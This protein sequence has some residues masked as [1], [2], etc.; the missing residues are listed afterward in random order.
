MEKAWC[1]S[2]KIKWLISLNVLAF[3]DHTFSI[4]KDN[5]LQSVFVVNNYIVDSFNKSR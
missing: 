3:C 2:N 5:C 4:N 1:V